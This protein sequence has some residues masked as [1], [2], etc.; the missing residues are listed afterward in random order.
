M[1]KVHKGNL[2]VILGCVIALMATTYFS[3]GLTFKTL[4]GC[5]V[6]L[7]TWIIVVIAANLKI[8]DFAK[9]LIIVLVP[10]YAILLYSGLCGGVTLAF[11]AS[12][13][14]LGMAVRYFNK[15]IIKF[16]AI[17]YVVVCI[18]CLIFDRKIID[19]NIIASISKMC[20]FIAAAFV[21]YLGTAY[22]EAKIKE[23]DDALE[24]V[25]SNSSISD[26]IAG[27]LNKEILACN[28]QV[29]DVTTTAETVRM[30]AEQMER[31]VDDSSRSIQ[32]VSEK[33]GITKEHIDKNYDCSKQLEISFNNVTKAV[34]EC[35]TEAHTVQKAMGDMSDTVYAASTAT[36]GLL[37]QMDE[38]NSIL[39]EIDAI[40][41][42]TNLLSLNA[43]IEAA[44][45]GEQ[46]RR[47]GPWIC[48]G[49]RTDKNAFGRQ[50]QIG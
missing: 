21:T 3:Y 11:M 16:Y 29:G 30:S 23:A 2:W 15:K 17:P 25:R 6:M 35:N 24:K 49:C 20:I 50:P 18:L 32:A 41:S 44:R 46:G 9:A 5:I 45:A 19:P 4:K 42:Q 40:A 33:L 1:N 43:S 27:D 10:S 38:I 48:C 12:F 47:T 36:K 34:L 7:A 22:G 28:N 39:N 14:T 31:V 37:S 8:S 13:I 26:E